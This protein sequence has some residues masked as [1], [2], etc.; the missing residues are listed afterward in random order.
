VIA[1][2]RY[3]ALAL[4]SAVALAAAASAPAK[5]QPGQP[6]KRTP[7]TNQSGQPD[8]RTAGQNGERGLVQFGLL[9]TRLM[10]VQGATGRGAAIV[11]I[12][13]LPDRAV[14]CYALRVTGFVATAAH[15][16]TRTAITIGGQTFAAG[17]IV[18]PLETPNALGFA[19]GCTNVSPAIGAAILANPQ[20]FYVNVHSAAFPAGQVEGT[21]RGRALRGR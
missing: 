2:K 8:K 6:D 18:V 13:V 9:R 3:L 17:G 21:L 5:D 12:L 7:V 16:H 20:N 14:V 1:V 4:V 10:P 15:I 11:A 19:I